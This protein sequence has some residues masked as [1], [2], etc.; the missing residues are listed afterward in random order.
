MHKLLRVYEDEGMPG[1][2]HARVMKHVEDGCCGASSGEVEV[3]FLASREAC[4]AAFTAHAMP[5][6]ADAAWKLV[7]HGN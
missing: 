2:W 6:L 7:D 5:E 1:Y 4:D 3:S